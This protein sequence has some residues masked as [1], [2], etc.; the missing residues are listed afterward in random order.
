MHRRRRAS[1]C[2]LLVLCVAALAGCTLATFQDFFKAYDEREKVDYR[3][4]GSTAQAATA[5]RLATSAALTLSS[6]TPTAAFRG[7]QVAVIGAAP[8]QTSVVTSALLLREDNCSLT[9][10]SVANAANVTTTITAILP[11]AG[12]YL[13]KL[14]GLTTTTGTFAKGCVDHALG[15]SS[16]PV[17]YLGRSSNGD[18]LSVSTDDIGKLT[19]WR[20]NTLGVALSRTALVN[21]G[22]GQTVAAADFNGDGI[23][24]VVTPYITVNGVSGIGVF[25]SHADGSFEPVV[26]YPGYPASVGRFGARVSI[27]DING[28]GKPDIVGVGAPQDFSNPTFVTLLGAGN[29]NF[30]RASASVKAM[31]SGF[32]VLADFNGDGRTD[33]LSS[34]GFLMP[35]NGD[36]SFG[37]P[38]QR[39]NGSTNTAGGHLAFGDLNGDGKLDVAVRAGSVISIF[40]GRGDGS[41]AAGP[42]YGT[43]RGAEYLNVTDVDGDGNAD[44][45][46]GLAGPRVYGPNNDSYTTMQFLMGRGDGSF[47]GAP[48]IPGLSLFTLA[49]FNGDGYPDLVAPQDG[50]NKVLELHAGAASASFAA[51]VGIAT[52]SISTQRLAAGD[53]DGDGKRD[54]I[55]GGGL[56][57]VLKSQGA[58]AF[59]AAQTYALPSTDGS[60]I[61]LA[62]ADFN[63][64]GRS[65]VLVIVGGQRATS[66]GAFVYFANADGTLKAPQQI[67]NAVNL[68]DVAVGDLNGDG[69]A[70][71]VLTGFDAKFYASP[72]VLTGARVVR[73]NADGSFSAPLLLAAPAGINYRAMALGDLNKDGKTDLV[74]AALD[75]GLNDIL[76]VFRGRGDGAFDAPA[77]IPIAGGG[78]G[79][80][81]LAIADFTYDGNP[82]LMIAGNIYTAI[83]V[84]QGDGTLG[85]QNALII[86]SGANAVIAADLNQ[87]TMMDAV[88]SATVGGA[89]SLVRV[90]SALDAGPPPPPPPPPPTDFTLALTPASG[91]VSSGQSLQTSATVTAAYSFDQSVSFSCSNLP[92]NARCSF[93]PASLMP[94]NGSGSSSLT[95]STGVAPSAAAWTG[96]ERFVAG[97][98]AGLALIGL[99]LGAASSR[100][101]RGGSRGLAL[102]LPAL[103]LLWVVVGCGGGSGDGSPGAGGGGGG[104]PNATP[105]GTYAVSVTATAGAVVKT[106]VFSLTVQ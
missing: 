85:G 1:R 80:K 61:N 82:D 32:F 70:D 42:S 40:T 36:G 54:L 27:E 78:P 55:A 77:V 43:V 98:G 104:N 83:R 10:Y 28:D 56:V 20:I 4:P 90:A 97:G 22:A 68:S 93:S 89:V 101:Q 17:V 73:G 71:I 41:F 79:I 50:N 92:A 19:L 30:T 66:G 38:V 69:R 105:S 75:A 21:D 74:V 6:Y 106:A 18:L 3:T 103:L 99:G 91:S 86:G 16:A 87:D 37:A 59:A 57:T 7:N 47:V 25:L 76:Y 39:L 29:G 33:L 2:L 88:V 5:H 14:A 94:V 63:G 62:V 72:N 52:L 45:V 65:D 96:V 53:V 31:D 11:G 26:V 48:A 13:H 15:V 49:D 8:V 23:A 34:G 58:G 51:P 67:D 102:I 44:I 12:A 46:V 9:Q 81:A 95:I 24:D 100:R 35:G 84:G 60:F 64:D